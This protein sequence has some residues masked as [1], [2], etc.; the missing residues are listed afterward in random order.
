VNTDQIV[1]TVGAVAIQ[2]QNNTFWLLAQ[3]AIFWVEQKALLVADVHIGKALSF[4]RLGVPVPSGTTQGNLQKLSQL[5]D[6][7]KPSTVYILG[8]LLHAAA[9]QDLSVVSAMQTWREQHSDTV[10]ILVNGNHDKKAGEPAL[11]L[12]IEVVPEPHRVAGFDL[13]HAL[14]TG[15]APNSFCFAGHIHPVVN[16]SGKG[17][18]RLRLPCFVLTDCSLVLPAMGEFTGGFEVQNCQENRLFAVANDTVI[19]LPS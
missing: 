3:R 5:I 7:L 6:Q 14:P 8:D 11:S 16:L 18:D 2:I 17:R 9:A 19:A 10:I 15:I 1:P 12:A 4:R 13:M